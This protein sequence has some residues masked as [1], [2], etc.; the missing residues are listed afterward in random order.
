MQEK[1]EVKEKD[2]EEEEEKERRKRAECGK[3]Y[4]PL[5]YFSF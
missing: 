3:R 2:E 5:I 1:D 4:V